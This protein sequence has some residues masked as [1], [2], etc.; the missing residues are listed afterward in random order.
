MCL[1]IFN[2]NSE[3]SN[4]RIDY[5]TSEIYSREDMDAAILIIKEFFS[6]WKGCE[7]HSIRYTDD[8]YCNSPKNIKW[9]NTLASGRSYEKNFDQC[10]AFFSDF[11]SPKTDDHKITFNINEEYINWTWYFSR[12]DKGEWQLMTFGY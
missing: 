11:H 5:G 10:I 2:S 8:D 6:K 4:V 3:A 1:M 12:S 9:M 7:L